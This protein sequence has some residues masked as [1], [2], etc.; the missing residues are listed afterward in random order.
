MASGKIAAEQ[1]RNNKTEFVDLA[2]RSAQKKGSEPTRPR[3]KLDKIG[4]NWTE[5]GQVR[6][7][8]EG[9]SDR[10]GDYSTIVFLGIG[11]TSCSMSTPFWTTT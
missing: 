3:K 4:R 9:K 2:P 8:T 6:T 7:E 10:L 1:R 11:R 5:T